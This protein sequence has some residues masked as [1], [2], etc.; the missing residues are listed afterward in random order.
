MKF[1]EF[2]YE[3]PNL[4]TI[5]TEIEQLISLIG[6]DQPYDVEK[7]AIFKV[8]EL[9]DRINTQASLV[10][11]RNSIDTKDEFYEKEQ[12]FL[13]ESMPHLQQFEHLFMAKL[14]KSKNRS[15]LEKDL[16]ELIFLRG[17]LAQKTFS[18]EIIGELT[19]RK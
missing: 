8:F 9:N 14:L 12:D 16:G 5:K 7:E 6:E 13:N 1:A 2:K 15:Q 17:E 3:R 18:P 19:T 10:S 11:V 4:E